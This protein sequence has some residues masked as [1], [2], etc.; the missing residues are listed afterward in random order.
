[1]GWQ[2]APGRSVRAASTVVL[3]SLCPW[4]CWEACRSHTRRYWY[5]NKPCG[6][7]GCKHA[8]RRAHRLV[9]DTI[10]HASMHSVPPCVSC[11]ASKASSPSDD[12]S[13]S[14]I[15]SLKLPSLLGPSLAIV[16]NADHARGTATGTFSGNTLQNDR[17]TARDGCDVA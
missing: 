9:Q 5:Q 2:G 3:H 15:S 8:F 16:A 11:S 13:S 14:P 17:N 10:T 7:V 6:T 12:S 1:M 4:R